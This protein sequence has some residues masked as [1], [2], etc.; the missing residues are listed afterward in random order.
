M[1]EGIPQLIDLTHAEVL[2]GLGKFLFPGFGVLLLL[3]VLFGAALALLTRLPEPYP[4]WLARRYQRWLGGLHHAAY[5]LFVLTGSFLICSTLARRSHDWEQ[6]HLQQLAQ[7]VEGER[8]EQQAPTVRYLTQETYRHAVWLDGKSVDKTDLRTVTHKLNLGASNLQVGI[9]QFVR[10][11]QTG[12]FGYKVDFQGDYTVTNAL[13]TAQTF[14]FDAYAPRAYSLLEAFRVSRDGQPLQ[15]AQVD[16]RSFKFSLAPGQTTHFRISYQAQGDPR[17]IYDA[18]QS[19]LSNFKLTLQTDFANADFASGIPPSRIDAGGAGKTFVWDFKE[20]VSVQHPFGVFTTAVPALA[21]HQSG[22]L[23]RLLL[24]MPGIFLWWLLLLYFTVPLKPAQILVYG[25]DMLAAIL[26]LTYFGRLA[27]PLP[28][29][30]GLALFVLLLVWLQDRQQGLKALPATVAGLL[31]PVLALLIPYSGL[32]LGVA[33]LLSALWLAFKR[34]NALPTPQ[35][36][37]DL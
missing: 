30:L 23:P 28:V 20:N 7:T 14:F 37:A 12:R 24:L 8:L 18:E 35:I 21:P 2:M 1:A 36:S 32:T 27:P 25:A 4:D 13:A 31:L 26:A 3:T 5:V 6:A 9:R 15:G 16:E 19:L 34:R 29:W 33:G 17:W 22:V 10:D 11:P